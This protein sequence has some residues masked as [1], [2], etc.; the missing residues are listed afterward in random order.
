MFIYPALRKERV[1]NDKKFLQHD[2]FFFHL[3]KRKAAKAMMM[4]KHVDMIRLE[5]GEFDLED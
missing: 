4:M 2:T 5:A 1:L 3:E